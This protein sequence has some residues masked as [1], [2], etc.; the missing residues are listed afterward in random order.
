M[1]QSISSGVNFTARLCFWEGE[2]KV[3][4][5][6]PDYKFWLLVPFRNIVVK[7]NSSKRLDEE[8]SRTLHQHATN[9]SSTLSLPAS[10]ST[11]STVSYSINRAENRGISPQQTFVHAKGR[12]LANNWT[13]IKLIYEKRTVNYPR[14]LDRRENNCPF[15][16]GTRRK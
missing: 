16:V 5:L 13:A 3:K 4:T 14:W 12:A 7:W 6:P 9:S 15:L 11:F 1:T 2:D 8:I 10:I